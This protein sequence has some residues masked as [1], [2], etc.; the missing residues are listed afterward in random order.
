MA[1]PLREGCPNRNF[2]IIKALLEKK[3][4]SNEKGFS[5][6][7]K[8]EPKKKTASLYGKTVSLLSPIKTYENVF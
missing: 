8:G 5:E 3:I 4:E 2:N 7:F 6:G 1:N